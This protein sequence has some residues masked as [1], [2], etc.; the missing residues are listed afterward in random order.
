MK[1]G[2]IIAGIAAAAVALLMLICFVNH[3][4]C[5]NR[6]KALLEPLGQLVEVD[7]GRMNVYSEG[8]GEQTIVFL[9]GGGTSS[10]VLDFRSLYSLLSDKYRIAVVEKFGYGFSDVS[11]AERDI[12]TILE[13]SRAALIKSGIEGPYVLCPHSM[14][15][16]EALYWAQKY[17]SEVSAIIGLDMAV[18]A[19]YEDYPANM[20]TIRL[21]YLGAR[22]GI[23]RLLPGAAESD[24]IRHGTLTEEEKDIY[25]AVFYNRTLTSDMLAEMESIK[26][27]AAKVGA[28]DVPQLPMLFFCSNGEG[29]AMDKAQ[30]VG[31]PSEYLR[32]VE[33][34]Q[35][36]ELD[37]PH[38]I[39]DYEYLRISE[40]IKS[41]LGCTAA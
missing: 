7:G 16:I 35:L 41:F 34:G 12:D 18:P 9:S 10:P 23:T 8:S 37:C 27:N 6:E 2:F 22:L 17:P 11:A 20:A 32:G 39:H 14:S 19:I 29:T 25:R 13:H 5:L 33:N 4:I 15:G 3:R 21:S 26:E 1:K 36:I 40:E 28:G 31:Y 24:A 38:Y 30:W